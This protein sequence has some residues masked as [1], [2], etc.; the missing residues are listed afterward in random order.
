MLK[1]NTQRLEIIEKKMEINNKYDIN[2]Q[3]KK[4]NEDINSK[5]DINMQ[6]G[7]KKTL[8]FHVPIFKSSNQN[9]IM[10]RLHTLTPV[11]E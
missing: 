4:K 5:Y 7:E 3:K 6:K 11:L 8:H 2:M 1:Y 10:V 9:L